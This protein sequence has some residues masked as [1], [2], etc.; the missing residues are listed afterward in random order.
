MVESA[1]CVSAVIMRLTIGVRRLVL[2]WDRFKT[3]LSNLGWALDIGINVLTGG[4]RETV[5]ARL[6][7]GKLKENPVAITT[8]RVLDRI[9][10]GHC[11][12]AEKWWNRAKDE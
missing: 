2:V 5:S 4:G 11:E 1:L 3:Y 8:C 6:G 7:R 12:A 10:P 9:D